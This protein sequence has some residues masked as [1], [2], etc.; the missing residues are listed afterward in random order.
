M[1]Y[2]FKKLGRQAKTIQ[3]LF[4]KSQSELFL[5]MSTSYDKNILSDLCPSIKLNEIE[6]F[7]IANKSC[8]GA[9]NDVFQAFLYY[10]QQTHLVSLFDRQDKMSMINAIEGRVPF[11]NVN[12]GKLANST[13]Y[14]QKISGN[15][16][17]FNLREI[18]RNFLPTEI[19]KRDKYAFALPI[20][21]WMRDSN[22]FNEMLENIEFGYL[23]RNNILDFQ[24]YKKILRS[25]QNGNKSYGDIV[26]NILNLDLACRIF[27]EKEDIVNYDEF[28]QRSFI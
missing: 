14:H 23:V 28:K 4:A 27:I 17:K 16:T 12:L 13:S 21:N 9:D 3:A 6:R 25:F 8:E 15:I 7:R 10:Y 26:W 11:I 19:F 18:A 2:V 20:Y 22:E 1:L 5:N 24:S